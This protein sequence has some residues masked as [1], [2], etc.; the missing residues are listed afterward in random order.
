MEIRKVSSI[1]A[2]RQSKSEAVFK[3]ANPEWT[4]KTPWSEPLK[5]AFNKAEWMLTGK[6][7]AIGPLGNERIV[8]VNF[9]KDGIRVF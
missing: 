1:K 5:S 3:R 7:K 9:Y 6:F 8:T 2:Y 4:V